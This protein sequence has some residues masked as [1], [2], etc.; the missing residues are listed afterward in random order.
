ML[1]A[2]FELLGRQEAPRA[3]VKLQAL[4]GHGDGFVVHVRREAEEL[5]LLHVTSREVSG[6]HERVRVVHVGAA[7]PGDLGEQQMHARFLAALGGYVGA[8]DFIVGQPG[9]PAVPVV[10]P[11]RAPRDQEEALQ[12]AE[13]Q[14]A[15]LDGLVLLAAELEREMHAVRADRVEPA[16]LVDELV[17][18]P[19][20]VGE[21]LGEVGLK[22]DVAQGD[23]EESAAR[24]AGGL[25]VMIVEVPAQFPGQG[26]EPEVVEVD[27]PVV[28]RI[29]DVRGA[30]VVDDAMPDVGELQLRSKRDVPGGH[31]IADE[32]ELVAGELGIEDRVGRDDGPADVVD[33]VVAP[34]VEF[35]QA[36]GHELVEQILGAVDHPQGAEGTEGPLVVDASGPHVVEFV[37]EVGADLRF[38]LVEDHL[39]DDE[40]EV[41]RREGLGLGVLAD[42]RK[43]RQG[44]VQQGVADRVVADAAGFEVAAHQVANGLPVQFR[45]GPPVGGRRAVKLDLARLR[46]GGL[47]LLAQ[48]DLLLERVA[49]LVA[50]RVLHPLEVPEEHDRPL[51]ASGRLDGERPPG[52]VPPLVLAQGGHAL[53]RQGPDDVSGDPSLAV[54]HGVEIGV[55]RADDLVPVQDG[56]AGEELL[57]VVGVGAAAH[58]LLAQDG[59]EDRRVLQRPVDEQIE[60]F[61]GRHVGPVTAARTGNGAWRSGRGRC[62]A[63]RRP[64]T[65]TPGRGVGRCAA[66]ASRRPGR[67]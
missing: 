63:S 62:P 41:V 10:G 28:R 7:P 5:E 50:E 12:G 21:R 55:V 47:D 17:Q 2:G 16:C 61:I 13:R 39:P 34:E 59:P 26:V 43:V 27:E 64:S 15:V 42:A 14:A 67:R 20:V 31:V 44:T 36:V 32:I 48:Q 1:G 9:D 30:G 11:H 60:W 29:A 24:A 19:G 38:V 6:P 57:D 40:F 58:D 35:G 45:H 23:L 22:R 4:E 66:A 49:E 25:L 53:V 54:G 33:Q 37:A 3:Q 8:Q 56:S 65:G 46:D 18:Q 51:G 52:I